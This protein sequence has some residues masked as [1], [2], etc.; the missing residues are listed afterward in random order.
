MSEGQQITRS[1]RFCREKYHDT[2]PLT[3]FCVTCDRVVCSTCALAG[4][5]KGHQYSTLQEA[6]RSSQLALKPAL[7][8]LQTL[9]TRASTLRDEIKVKQVE[10]DKI[11]FRVEVVESLM[12][13]GDSLEDAL[14]HFALVD[15]HKLELKG[16]SCVV[17]WCGVVCGVWCVVCGVWCVVCG[18]VR[19]CHLTDFSFRKPKVVTFI[20][21]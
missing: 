13:L 9:Q 21:I 7:Q 2:T 4:S 5:H 8:T 15:Q 11:E 3:L 12:N 17:V 14:L 1:S 6:H 20:F 16:Q 19:Y 10:L 18:V